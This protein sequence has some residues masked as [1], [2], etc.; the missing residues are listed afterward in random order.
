MVPAWPCISWQIATRGGPL[1]DGNRCGLGRPESCCRSLSFCHAACIQP[2]GHGNR[3]HPSNNVQSPSRAPP[4]RD[5]P[6]VSFIIE[7]SS[8]ASRYSRKRTPRLVYCR[9]DSTVEER[10]ARKLGIKQRTA[11]L[12]I[13]GAGVSGIH[14][15]IGPRPAR[16]NNSASACGL[17][18]LGLLPYLHRTSCTAPTVNGRIYSV[19]LNLGAVPNFA[20]VWRS[21]SLLV[22]EPL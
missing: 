14:S 21:E 13:G 22:R 6:R 4:L 8:Q 5:R 2:L 18:H 16:Y 10:W 17:C 7:P 1:L 12:L 20:T 19:G 9:D 3:N 11:R 15:D